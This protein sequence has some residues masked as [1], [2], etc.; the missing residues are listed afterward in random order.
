MHPLTVLMVFAALLPPLGVVAEGGSELF[1]S[2]RV[3][4]LRRLWVGFDTQWVDQ[5]LVERLLFRLVASQSCQLKLP[6]RV[7][8]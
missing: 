1:G 6:V 5:R 4:S 7:A 3:G 2:D 8:S